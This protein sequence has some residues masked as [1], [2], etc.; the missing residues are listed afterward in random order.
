M[1]THNFVLVAMSVCATVTY[2]HAADPVSVDF[3]HENLEPYGDWREVG[4]YGYCWQPRNVD[5][6]WGPYREGHWLYTDAGWTWDSEEPY[7][8][9]VYH[10]GRWARLDRVGWVW[11]PGT[12]WGPAWVSWR[13]S[14]QHVGWAPLPPDA[15]FNRSVGFSSRVDADYDIGPANYRFVE[16][17][18]FG[19]PQLRTVIVEPR[20]NIT[21]IRETTNITRITYVNNLVYNEGPRYDVISRESAQPIRRLR[22]ERR[23]SLDGGP[24][25]ERDEQMRARVDGDSFRVLALPFDSRPATAPRKVAAKVEKVDVD[26]GWKNAGPPE[27]VTALRAK[28][29]SEPAIAAEPPAKPGKTAKAPPVS[30]PA[31]DEKRKGRKTDAPAKPTAEVAAPVPVETTT[32][33]GQA[34]PG[35]GKNATK[36]SKPSKP[37]TGD[38][39]PAPA[40]TNDAPPTGE[41]KPRRSGPKAEDRPEARPPAPVPDPRREKEPASPP[42]AGG[43]KKMRPDQ[44]ERSKPEPRQERKSPEARPAAGPNSTSPPSTPAGK[45]DGKGK[46]KKKA[47]EARP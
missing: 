25:R 39:P 31:P 41:L 45:E 19:A 32:P 9:A 21:I 43:D 13:H 20:Q 36:P 37:E 1:K 4:D 10:Y 17:R 38:A 33:Q 3:F 2:I 35:M 29:K 24:G 47:D 22:L 14:P 15:E 11:V 8:W 28:M 26:R 23:G 16:V 18:N 6:N 44:V 27:E 40:V 30:T 12:E 46:G 34:R 7:S 42:P 5:E